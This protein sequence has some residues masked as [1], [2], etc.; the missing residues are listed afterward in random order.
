MLYA[1][2]EWNYPGEDYIYPLNQTSPQTLSLATM[3][4]QN[5]CWIAVTW[6][7]WGSIIGTTIEFRVW[8]YCG[9]AESKNTDYNATANISK[10][11]IVLDSD[12]NYPR[13]VGEVYIESG[14]E[15]RHDLGQ[16]PFVRYW[17]KSI[18]SDFKLPDG[19]IA[20]NMTVYS[21]GNDDGFIGEWR[22]NYGGPI[23]VSDK[24]IK[25]FYGDPAYGLQGIYCR[26]YLI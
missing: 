22:E 3:M 1:S 23:Q 13:Y 2:G 15:Y 18:S 14:Q 9:D 6:L 5:E 21:S 8:A 19:S 20:S 7:G 25:T 26:I 16:I 10:S 24:I 11:K 17:Y 4:F 12:R